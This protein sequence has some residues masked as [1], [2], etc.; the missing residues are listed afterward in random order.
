MNKRIATH[1]NILF[2]KPCVAGTCITV[3]NVLELVREGISAEVIRK[4]YYPDLTNED[5]GACANIANLSN[6]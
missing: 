3:Q 5:L 4:D 2:G 1:T 6:D